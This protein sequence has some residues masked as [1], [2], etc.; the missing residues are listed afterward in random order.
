MDSI[1]LRNKP[2]DN[3]DKHIFWANAYFTRKTS[4]FVKFENQKQ[5][6]ILIEIKNIFGQTIYFESITNAIGIQSKNIDISLYPK[7]VYF[8]QLQNKN[9]IISEKFIKQ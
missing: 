7:G 9:S 6:N 3:E 8:V 1:I 4:E 2:Y 5:Q